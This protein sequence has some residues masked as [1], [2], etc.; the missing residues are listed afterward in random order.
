MRDWKTE[1]MLHHQ[2]GCTKTDKISIKRGIFQGDSLVPFFCL[3]LT[4]LSNML[5]RLNIGYKIE[6]SQQ[7]LHLIYMD[8]LKIFTRTEAHLSKALST[9]KSFTDDISMEFGLDKCATAVMKGGE[10]IKSQ[11]MP[12]DDKTSIQSL[13]EEV[14]HKYLD[15]DENSGIQQSAMKEK[16]AK[17]YY[18]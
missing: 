6:S 3:A 5:N 13:D 7:I 16:I 15:I 4:P 10:Q 1:L 14:A 2:S 12:I 9:V 11:N 18:H 17:E 8:D